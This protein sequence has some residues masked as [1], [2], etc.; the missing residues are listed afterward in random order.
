M[1]TFKFPCSGKLK[2]S[3]SDMIS[4]DQLNLI[5]D[6]L[7]I[8]RMCLAFLTMLHPPHIQGPASVLFYQGLEYDML[9]QRIRA[10]RRT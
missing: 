1:D 8:S 9:T 10:N 6:L 2:V 4:P 7:P 5:L 3:S